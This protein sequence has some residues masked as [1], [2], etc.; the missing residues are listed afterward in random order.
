MLAFRSENNHLTII[1]VKGFYFFSHSQI[2]SSSLL[3]V[4]FFFGLFAFVAHPQLSAH[5]LE[6]VYGD[7]H[8]WHAAC[9]NAH[10]TNDTCVELSVA[11]ALKLT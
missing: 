11:E 9:I 3:L 1:A 5:E 10:T 2:V 6:P 7:H 8:L 4:V